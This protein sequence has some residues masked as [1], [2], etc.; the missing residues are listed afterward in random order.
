MA[1][2]KRNQY[3]YDKKTYDHIHLQVPKGKKAEIKAFA[4]SKG[5]SLNKFINEAI[6][7][8]IKL[9]SCGK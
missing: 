4:D 1:D 8:K 6:A 7:E 3:A 5:L 9:E 2:K